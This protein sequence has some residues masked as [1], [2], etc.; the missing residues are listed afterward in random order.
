MFS[1][2]VDPTP[3]GPTQYIYTFSEKSHEIEEILVRR[4]VRTRSAPLK[5]ATG[6]FRQ[7]VIVMPNSN[8]IFAATAYTSVVH[9]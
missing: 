3:W 4:G 9:I 6:V 1:T 7:V 5:S 8:T 2:G